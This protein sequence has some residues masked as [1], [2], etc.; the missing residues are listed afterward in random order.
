MIKF[1]MKHIIMALVISVGWMIIGWV[2]GMIPGIG[3]FIASVIQ[4]AWTVGILVYA[5]KDVKGYMEGIMTGITYAAVFLAVSILF[6]GIIS[7]GGSFYV[8]WFSPMGNLMSSLESALG[9]MFGG[10]GAAPT[11]WSMMFGWP[12]IWGQVIGFLVFTAMLG[13]INTQK[14]A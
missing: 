10:G 13:W 12:G 9:G 7:W 5:F 3:S 6:Q 2:L 8:H 1:E 14:Q 4:L 11:Y